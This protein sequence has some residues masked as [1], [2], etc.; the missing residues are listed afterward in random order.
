MRKSP[1]HSVKRHVYHVCTSCSTGNAIEPENL[2]HGTG[3]KPMC[4]ECRD[5]VTKGNC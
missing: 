1:W 4:K 2:R 5:C 3:G